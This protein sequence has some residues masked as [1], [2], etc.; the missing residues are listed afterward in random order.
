M[1]WDSDWAHVIELLTVISSLAL[2]VYQN[3]DSSR[4]GDEL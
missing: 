1:W 3:K 2:A 4:H